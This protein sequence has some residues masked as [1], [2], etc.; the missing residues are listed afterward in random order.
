MNVD[1]SQTIRNS[2]SFYYVGENA[3]D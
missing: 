2:V 1:E 3:E